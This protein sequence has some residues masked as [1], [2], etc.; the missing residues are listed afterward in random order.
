[1]LL[2]EPLSAALE[3][4]RVV[5]T[6]QDSPASDFL[7]RRKHKSPKFLVVVARPNAGIFLRSAEGGS[8]QA[9]RKVEARLAFYVLVQHLQFNCDVKKLFNVRFA[10]HL[11][12][13]S[14]LLQVRCYVLNAAI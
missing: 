13:L 4:V 14:S 5:R 2:P 1:M 11:S 3:D 10:R 12:T 9:G 8:A 7:F 6:L